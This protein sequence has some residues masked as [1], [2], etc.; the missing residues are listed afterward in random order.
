MI[1]LK[2]AFEK[3]HDEMML[4]KSYTIW[5]LKRINSLSQKEFEELQGKGA[6]KK[7]EV[8]RAKKELKERQENIKVL[9]KI[10]KEHATNNS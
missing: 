10:I 6:I 7:L 1:T 4:Q 8:E 5:W 3:W 9:D 2:E